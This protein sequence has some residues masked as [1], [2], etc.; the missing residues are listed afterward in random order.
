MRY[1]GV[2]VTSVTK[3]QLACMCI[4]WSCTYWV[5]KSEG[6]GNPS[7][8]NVKYIASVRPSENFKIG[9]NF[10][11]HLSATC[12]WWAF[13]IAFCALYVVNILPCEHSRFHIYCLIFMKFCR[14][15]VTLI[16]RL[17]SKLGHAGSK[18]RS[19]GKKNNKKTCEHCTS[20]IFM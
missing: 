6:Q 7:R 10:W 20:P 5:V 11:A 16:P 2:Y 17:S 9:H 18:I 1:V 12:S 14:T 15:F 19:L 4:L 13:V 3:L 8:L